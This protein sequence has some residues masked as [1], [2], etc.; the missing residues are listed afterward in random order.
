MSPEETKE[1]EAAQRWSQLLHEVQEMLDT[2]SRDEII[3]GIDTLLAM[4][5]GLDKQ[6]DEHIKRFP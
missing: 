1:Y 5:K 2:Y 6:M 3:H 4:R